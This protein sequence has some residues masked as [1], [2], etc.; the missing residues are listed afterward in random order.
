MALI[1]C[2]QCN[3]QISDA[4]QVCP[5]CGHPLHPTDNV[6]NNSSN[7]EGLSNKKKTNTKVL[8]WIGAA[9][10]V[11]VLIVALAQEGNGE[12][13]TRSADYFGSYITSSCMSTRPDQHDYDLQSYAS[14]AD[15]ILI[16]ISTNDNYQ[17]ESLS[18]QLATLSIRISV[19]ESEL[20]LEQQQR[21]ENISS[22]FASQLIALGS[23]ALWQSIFNN[24]NY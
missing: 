2:P 23:E 7:S 13:S 20:T 16:A 10:V 15:Q 8:L 22:Q 1:Q 11:I 4:A 5:K 12:S 18:K 19:Y 17:I 24:Y 9:I 6:Q 3:N 21:I 14:L